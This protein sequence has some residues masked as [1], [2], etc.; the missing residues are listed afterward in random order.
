MHGC[1]GK[2]GIG[3]LFV[4]ILILGWSDEMC[5]QLHD[6]RGWTWVMSIDADRV[7]IREWERKEDM[8]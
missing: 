8:A 1:L 7:I 6:R 5:Y 4:I 3:H 2:S